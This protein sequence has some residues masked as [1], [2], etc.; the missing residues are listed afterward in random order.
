[1]TIVQVLGNR[2][3][4]LAWVFAAVVV[5]IATTLLLAWPSGA[6]SHLACHWGHY[7]LADGRH[8]SVLPTEREQALRIMFLDGE[9]WRLEA[10]E[11]AALGNARRF[12]ALRG[13]TGRPLL[14]HVVEFGPCD[15]ETIRIVVEGQS[16][17]GTRTALDV[18]DTTFTRLGV[19]LAGRLVMP[20]QA[21]GIPV[22]VLLHGSERHSALRYNRFQHLLP[23]LGVGVFVFDKRGTG[24]SQGRYTQDFALLAD[25]AVAA[26]QNAREL[27]GSRAREVGFEGG[28]QAGWV[29][30]LAANRGGA[31]FVVV[32]FG[33]AESPLAED[34]EGVLDALRRRGWGDDVLA[35]ASE[36]TNATARVM[37]SRFTE[38]FDALD[39]VRE[40]YQNEPWFA[41][42]KGDLSGNVLH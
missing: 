13:W 35:S 24:D 16:T 1:M 29:A 22:A 30:P 8:V 3:R 33:L 26:L 18:T 20:K 5:T 27:A 34:R 21:T 7:R 14:G 9:T 4:I 40:K 42:V 31:G 36:I 32:S 10:R 39:A 38:G 2:R 19:R 28:S 23:G 25:D 12:E 17:G 15:D 6:A 37:S 41:E 11:G